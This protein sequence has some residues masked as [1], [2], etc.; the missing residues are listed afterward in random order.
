MSL[1]LSVWIVPATLSAL[2]L[3]LGWPSLWIAERLWD[4]IKSLRGVA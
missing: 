4:E 2:A 1:L 3:L